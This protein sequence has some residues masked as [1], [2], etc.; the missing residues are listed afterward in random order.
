MRWEEENR[1]VLG[2]EVMETMEVRARRWRC[3]VGLVI[4]HLGQDLAIKVAIISFGSETV[5][6]TTF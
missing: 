2:V 6:I 3:K 5:G 1:G 4:F